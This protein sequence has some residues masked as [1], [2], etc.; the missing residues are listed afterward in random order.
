MN[1]YECVFARVFD[2]RFCCGIS[3]R[4]HIGY[5]HAVEQ[6]IA[7]GNMIMDF[8]DSFHF[9]LN[10]CCAWTQEPLSMSISCH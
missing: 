1:V 10:A 6:R 8:Y 2:V 5:A 9:R 3:V 7:C 4:L